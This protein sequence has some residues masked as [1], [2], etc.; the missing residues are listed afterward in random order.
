MVLTED[1]LAK[2][3][4]FLSDLE[5]TDPPDAA[6]VRRQR[7]APRPDWSRMDLPAIDRAYRSF[8]LAQTG[9]AIRAHVERYGPDFQ[10]I[11]HDDLPRLLG[12]CQDVL[13]DQRIHGTWPRPDACQLLSAY[14]TRARRYDLARR[15]ELGFQRHVVRSVPHNQRRASAAPPRD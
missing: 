8:W 7:Q 9:T 13:E 10:R 11:I 4:A 14:L 3:S 15:V 5:T 1:D 2:V 6:R 12:Y